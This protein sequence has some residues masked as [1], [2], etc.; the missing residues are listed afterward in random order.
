MSHFCLAHPSAVEMLETTCK[1]SKKYRR[2]EPSISDVAMI[3]SVFVIVVAVLTH[4]SLAAKL[5]VFVKQHKGQ[6]NR[7]TYFIYNALLN[8]SV[9]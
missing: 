9:W 8:G 5:L 2:G 6:G 1:M 7:T 3:A 4:I